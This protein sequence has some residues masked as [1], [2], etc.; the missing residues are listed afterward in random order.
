MSSAESG[1]TICKR[2]GYKTEYIS[3]VYYVKS[4]DKYKILKNNA[5]FLIPAAQ[6]EYIKPP[7]PAGF[8]QCKDISKLE[9]IVEK[10]YKLW[11]DVEASKKLIPLYLAHDQSD[12]AINL[13]EKLNINKEKV[14]FDLRKSYWKALEMADKKDR[15]RMDL[16]AAMKDKSREV[17]AK[18]YIVNGDLLMSQYNAKDALVDGY[19]RAVVVYSDVKSLRKEALAKTIKAMDSLRDPKAYDMRLLLR[20]EFPETDK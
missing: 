12:K 18:A 19:L 8:D 5:E 6:V 1:K 13:F 2:K 3:L 9:A 14:P 20:K 4:T 17:R 15:L 10:Y 11:W 16:N 7:K